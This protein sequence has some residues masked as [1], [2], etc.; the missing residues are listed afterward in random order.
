MSE[1]ELREHIAKEIETRLIWKEAPIEIR[2]AMNKVAQR[3]ADI[4]RGTV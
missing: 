2:S 1:Q 4:A 3:A